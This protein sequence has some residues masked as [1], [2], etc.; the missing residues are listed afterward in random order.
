MS[1]AP[2]LLKVPFVML[3]PACMVLLPM[4]AIVVAAEKLHRYGH[5]NPHVVL[6][7]VVEHAGALGKEAMDHFRRCRKLVK[8]RLSPHQDEVSTWSSRGFSNFFLQ[9]ISVANL[10]P[11]H[12][13]I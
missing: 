8:N 3:P 6:P 5:V 12:Q 10:N 1:L 4:P 7:F 2:P 13:L 11:S 9:A